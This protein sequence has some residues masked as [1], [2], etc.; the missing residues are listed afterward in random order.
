MAAFDRVYVNVRMT[1]T[2]PAV[3]ES[4]YALESGQPVLVIDDLLIVTRR[5]T[6]RL[7]S[8]QGV[9]QD[10]LDVRFKVGGFFQRVAGES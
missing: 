3:Q 9:Q 1:G 10:Q 7:R 4:L 8:R 5:T 6:A 2:T